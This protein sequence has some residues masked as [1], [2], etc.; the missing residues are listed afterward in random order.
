MKNMYSDKYFWVKYNPLQSMMIH[1]DWLLFGS[2]I[3]Q[4]C[5]HVPLYKGEVVDK[6]GEY[7]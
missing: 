7:Q 4:L 2:P 6:L 3:R 5:S 1:T